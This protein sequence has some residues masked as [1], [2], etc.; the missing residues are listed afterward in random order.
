MLF[1]NN[2][3]INSEVSNVTCAAIE[4][5]GNEKSLMPRRKINCYG[6]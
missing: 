5:T 2:C 4:L 3:L 6:Y 1:L